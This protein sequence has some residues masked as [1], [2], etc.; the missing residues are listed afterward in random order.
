MTDRLV[1][2]NEAELVSSGRTI[3]HIFIYFPSS[4]ISLD[5]LH[6]FQVCLNSHPYPETDNS[7]VSIKKILFVD[8]V[9]GIVRTGDFLGY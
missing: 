1:C 8:R 2:K 5:L 6:Q 7:S 9:K 3:I 4:L